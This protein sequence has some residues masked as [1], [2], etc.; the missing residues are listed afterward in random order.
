[1]PK[2][3]AELGSCQIGALYNDEVNSLLV[4]DGREES[5]VY[6]TAVGRPL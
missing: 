2:T 4:V 3:G 5:M 1:V 6:M